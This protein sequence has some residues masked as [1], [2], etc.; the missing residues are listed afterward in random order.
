MRMVNRS[1]KLLTIVVGL[2]LAGIGALGT[3]GTV[4]PEEV[5]VWFEVAATAVLVVGVLLPG[6]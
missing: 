3:F 1:P 5:G 6:V 4:L 2:I